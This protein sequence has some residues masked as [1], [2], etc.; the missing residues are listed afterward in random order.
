MRFSISRSAVA[1]CLLFG[2]A[3]HADEPGP[4]Y[5]PQQDQYQEQGDYQYGPG[6]VINNNNN[7]TIVNRND[8]FGLDDPS[9]YYVPGAG[10]PVGFQCVSCFVRMLN[11]AFAE[12]IAQNPGGLFY[13]IWAGPTGPYNQILIGAVNAIKSQTGMCANLPFLPVPFARP[14]VIVAPRPPVIIGRPRFP[15]P[16]PG[17]FRPGPGRPGHHH[18]RR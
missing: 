17:I 7:I 5:P 6:Q 13:R 12:V 2:L 9:Q 1:A 16:G 14:P 11:P 18:G 3:A 4:D 8:D 10:L 15:R